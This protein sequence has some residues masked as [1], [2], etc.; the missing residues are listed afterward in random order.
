MDIAEWLRTLGLGQ[1]APAFRDNDIT[2]E[3]LPSLTADDLKELGV[4]SVGLRR[5]LLD[6]IAGL[7][8]VMAPPA[9]LGTLAAQAERRQITFLFCDLVGSSAL[10]IRLDLELLRDV[11]SSYYE[12]VANVIARFDGFVARYMGDGALAYF[13]YPQAHEDAARLAVRAGLALV[14]AVAALPAP[15]RLHAR[16]GIATGLVVVGDLAGAATEHEVVGEAPNLAAR[17]QA[18][19][20]PDSVVI[21]EATRRLVGTSFAVDPVGSLRLKGWDTP[22]PVWR[23]TGENPSAARFN[24]AQSTLPLVDRVAELQQLRAAWQ[25]VVHGRGRTVVL[26]GEAGIGKSRLA[27]AFCAGL[28]GAGQRLLRFQCSPSH[29]NTALHPVLRHFEA[30]AGFSQDDPPERRREKLRALLSRASKVASDDL[31]IIAE[32]MALPMSAAHP[33]PPNTAQALDRKNRIF[34]LLLRYLRG[35]PEDGPPLLL[36]ED[37]HWG[38][39]TTLELFDRVVDAITESCGLVIATGRPEFVPFGNAKGAVAQITLDRLGAD[40][41]GK[42][43]RQFAG[44][45]ELPPH[46]LDEILQKTDG[47]PLF[48]EELTKNILESDILVESADRW[49]LRG[50]LAPEHIPATL[51]DSLMAR[52]D[53]LGP[54]KELAQIAAALGREFSHAVLTAVT[55]LAPSRLRAGLDRLIEAQLIVRRDG[56]EAADYMFSHALVQDAAYGSMLST[57]RRPL[58]SRVAQVL[59]HQFPGIAETQPELI[60][61]HLTEAQHIEQAIGWWL[62]AGRRNAHASANIEAIA[63]F[64]RCLELLATLPDGPERESLE[65][66]VRIDLG[67]PL[68]G[69]G[70]YTAPEFLSNTT[71]ALALCERIGDTARLYPVLW[72]QI[73]HFF[74]TG[75]MTAAL[76]LARRFLAAAERQGDRQLRMV[77]ERLC[78]LTSF[79]LGDLTAA[80]RHFETTLDLYDRAQDLPLAYIYGLDQRVAA[81][82]Y[83][84]ITVH[85]LGYPDQALGSAESALREACALEHGTSILYAQGKMI[86]LRVLR[87]EWAAVDQA[88]AQHVQTARERGAANFEL[89]GRAAVHIAQV[90]QHGTGDAAVVRHS[91]GELRR[92][93]WNYQA[94]W[95]V[96]ASAEVFAARRQPAQAAAWLDQA[97]AMIEG[98]APGVW[99]PDLHLARA[100]TLASDDAPAA[101]LQPVL[102]QAIAAARAQS[103][104]LPEL[105]AATALARLLAA[106]G[107][108]TDAVALLA[109]LFAG[110]GERADLRDLTEAEEL[111]DAL[112]RGA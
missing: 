64:E 94:T 71:R 14:G 69:V 37:A 4:A 27:S 62:R 49:Q 99:L 73:T 59:E 110:I 25:E 101:T 111:L 112:R 50:P 43:V 65:L 86:E 88:A 22:L 23:V 89:I 53:R 103:A 40:D 12:T 1:Y 72:G 104:Y 20:A 11:I 105:R 77:G 108:T 96:L 56:N 5:R 32:L 41:S 97:D 24:A 76:P 82:A 44:G 92:L 57:R 102:E 45:R 9:P 80:R 60:A 30:A 83:L 21:A 26:T 29:A 78:G 47:I 90:M 10:A 6:A 67:V 66:D 31:A 15:E 52:L 2:E 51:H 91:I 28:E 35:T 54:V 106:K 34:S 58:H 36:L 55:D 42:M 46:L 38:D 109:P 19:A 39:P 68:T 7:S 17:L 8:E 48:V 95:L 3:L 74:S 100:A 93:D 84:A 79:G 63:H 18:L 87:R 107:R 85:R 16:V 81:L 33:R 61:H 98:H 13:G 70:G 75:N